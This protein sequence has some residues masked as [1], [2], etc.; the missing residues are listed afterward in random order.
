MNFNILKYFIRVNKY[1]YEM[2]AYDKTF[3]QSIRQ[4]ELTEEN[5]KEYDRIVHYID[6][7]R[8]LTNEEWKYGNSCLDIN[9]LNR[10]IK[11]INRLLKPYN[12]QVI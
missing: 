12:K 4:M 5:C 9:R 8:K 11:K 3:L 1:K 10:N 7:I 6:K 2:H